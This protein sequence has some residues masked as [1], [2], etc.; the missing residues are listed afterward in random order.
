MPRAPAGD[1]PSRPQPQE[2]IDDDL[3]AHPTW[4]LAGSAA[5]RPGGSVG[6]NNRGRID[7][8]GLPA[9][10]DVLL[11]KTARE[12][13]IL[14]SGGAEVKA[15]ATAGQANL[16]LGMVRLY[17]ATA[18]RT[19]HMKLLVAVYL[20]F[21]ASLVVFACLSYAQVAIGVPFY[22]W[23][24][25][26]TRRSRSSGRSPRTCTRRSRANASSRS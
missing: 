2:Q 20:F 16:L 11:L 13:L 21:A 9:A 14:V 1:H 18:K 23:V 12:P 8:H 19:D 4:S 26:F 5:V 15:Y 7:D 6:G 17:G 25:V 10:R 24:G 3:D 22:P